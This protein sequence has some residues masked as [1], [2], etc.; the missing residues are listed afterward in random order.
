MADD[1]M[2]LNMVDDG[3]AFRALPVY[4]GG[5]WKDRLTARKAAQHYQKRV[6]T[7]KQTEADAARAAKRRRVEKTESDEAVPERH[8][9][10]TIPIAPKPPPNADEQPK[11]FISSLFTSNPVPKTQAEETN[12]VDRDPVMP[13]NAPLDDGL[14]NFTALGLS[15]TLASHLLHKMDVKAPTA[16]QETALKELLK[17]DTDAFIQ[18]ETGS[19]K[20]LAYL[21]PIVQRLMNVSKAEQEDGSVGRIHRNSGLFAIILAPTRELSKQISVVLKSLLRCAHWIVPGTV[22]GGEKK[23]SEKARLRK[24]LNILVATP[25]RLYDHLTTTKS[26]DASNVRWLVLDEGDRLMELGFF[27]EIHRIVGRL[28]NAMKDP[29]R[30]DIPGLPTSRNTTLCSATLKSDVERLGEISL[31]NAVH[32]QAEAGDRDDEQHD[33]KEEVKDSDKPDVFMPPAQLQ[34]SYV[35]VPAKMRLVTLYAYLKQVFA[36]AKPDSKAIVFMSCS[37]SVDFH[38]D[39]LTR[40]KEEED[41]DDTAQE[42]SPTKKPIN[43]PIR[44]STTSTTT[45][46]PPNATHASAPTISPNLHVHK[47]H[48]KL[49]Q[50]L[51]TATLSSFATTPRPALLLCTDV[52]SRGLDL[53]RVDAVLEFDPAFSAQDH[54]HRVGRT[55]RAG[56]PGAAAVFLLP[57]PEEAYVD[58]LARAARTPPRRRTADDVCAAAFGPSPASTSASASPAK[59]RGPATPPP[60]P[61]RWHALATAYQLRA[62]RWALARAERGAAARRAFAAHVRAYATHVA[63]ERAAFDL[64]ALHLG[65]L[66]KAFALRE[67]PAGMG[68]GVRVGVGAGK[69]KAGGGEREGGGK[70]GRRDGERDGDGAAAA[71]DPDEARRK[72]RAKMKMA[73]DAASEFNIG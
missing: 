65:H 62:E 11:Q 50:P 20:T 19:G 5:H 51:R 38:F 3:S 7:Q 30:K 56:R 36:G 4:K 40:T 53:P 21:L 15:P 66:A 2:M 27:D 67:R 71:P 63:A 26:F 10:T 54:L 42:P 14:S 55:A 24:G 46:T 61:P 18:A 1:G 31:K 29:R 52:A 70:R 34:Q 58:V 60:P 17:T 13:S 22:I 25:G 64:R 73:M 23:K 32:V 49:P 12:A 33:E 72:M 43:R 41:D 57:G 9:A 59:G 47:L 37:D 69:G 16:I 28:N 35:V 45:T 48:G 39:V 8:V 68:M 44:T 6:A